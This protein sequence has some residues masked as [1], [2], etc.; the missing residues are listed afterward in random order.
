MG[1]SSREVT[2][3]SW[4]T[5]DH[6]D[7]R[8][9]LPMT[10]ST[11]LST[12]GSDQ[13]FAYTCRDLANAILDGGFPHARTHRLE[14][15]A[16]GWAQAGIPLER[17]HTQV[18]EHIKHAMQAE[19]TGAATGAGLAALMDTVTTVLAAVSAAYLG[20]LRGR[21]SARQRLM[22]A[23]LNGE[24]TTAL[25]RE[26][27]LRIGD[28]YSVI[29]V[30]FP[31]TGGYPAS[32]AYT[33]EEIDAE[34][35]HRFG[36]GV[37]TRLSDEGGTVLAPVSD[38]DATLEHLLDALA[39]TVRA[40]LSAATASASPPG[41]PAAARCAHELL[42]LALLFGRYGTLCRFSDLAAEYQL[43]RPGPAR[44]QLA[45]LLDPLDQSPHLTATLQLHL[46]GT[47]SRRAVARRLHIHTNT[48]EYR[49]KRVAALTGLDP[50]TPE[51]QWQLRCAMV[52]RSAARGTIAL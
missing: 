26:C 7:L 46:R 31:L 4:P 14:T 2:S 44:D 40:R 32:L 16:T 11:S 45:A 12:V 41:L 3:A 52:A 10:A 48:V 21:L 19:V 22:S 34:L 38:Q 37:L 36:P 50:L 13:V 23:L 30:A 20:E 24:D 15:I 47:S 43:A 17:I 33:A 29:A 27:G 39:R 1:H 35:A 18:W 8:C 51:G 25:A 42:D 49:L 6:I 5:T 9:L 28:T